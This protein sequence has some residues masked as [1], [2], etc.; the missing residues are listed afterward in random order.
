MPGRFA[1]PYPNHSV[2]FLRRPRPYTRP[3]WRFLAWD[4][5]NLALFAQFPVVKKAA[6]AFAI[7]FALGQGG[8]PYGGNTHP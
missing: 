5:N 2:F 8:L 4:I 7:Y 6:H 1:G 3:N